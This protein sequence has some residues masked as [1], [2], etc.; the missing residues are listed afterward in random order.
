MAE[1]DSDE[2]RLTQEQIYETWLLTEE[3][4]VANDA[5]VLGVERQEGEDDQ[6][7]RKRLEYQR[8]FVSAS[9]LIG[10]GNISPPNVYW[11]GARIIRERFE[12]EGYYAW[13]RKNNVPWEDAVG[14]YIDRHHEPMGFADAFLLLRDELAQ[15]VLAEQGLEIT[16]VE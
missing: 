8:L 13:A 12:N 1:K 10:L 5:A 14:E 15:K 9:I 4:E 7:F 3:I 11:P 6:T 2:P 16:D